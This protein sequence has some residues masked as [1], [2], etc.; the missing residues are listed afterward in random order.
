MRFKDLYDQ[1]YALLANGNFAPGAR[2]GVK[3]LA[4]RL[5]VSPTPLREILS[6]LVGKDIIEEHR[7]EGYYLV[8]FD[9]RRIGDLYALHRSC[10]DLA[11]R[12]PSSPASLP[13]LNSMPDVWAAL[14]ALV[15]ATG[16]T[17]LLQTRRYLDGH[18]S[19][20]RRCERRLFQD[21]EAE[22]ARHLVVLGNGTR[23]ARRGVVRAFHHRR[24]AHARQLAFYMTRPT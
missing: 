11:L 12:T 4:D 24:I 13:P 20:L 9:A 15:E 2:L 21:L 19:L 23:E 1:V 18:L 10:I 7:S 5:N 22:A 16:N 14:D 8:G 17:A 3:E 6:R